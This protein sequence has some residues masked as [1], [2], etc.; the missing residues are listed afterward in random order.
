MEVVAFW[1][2]I[3]GAT[4]LQLFQ[5]MVQGTTSWL[6]CHMEPTPHTPAKS[7]SSLGLKFEIL[8]FIQKSLCIGQPM[9]TG[10]SNTW[11]ELK[12]AKPTDINFHN[13]SWFLGKKV[14]WGRFYHMKINLKIGEGCG[15]GADSCPIVIIEWFGFAS[16]TEGNY[17]F[18]CLFVYIYFG[19]FCP[20]PLTI[21]KLLNH[22]NSY[23][24][25]QVY[26]FLV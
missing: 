9:S 25:R 23:Q 16:I 18:V 10:R 20:F 7:S 6:S 26:C 5:G 4:L 17:I 12:R 3:A 14:Y 2:V 11:S 1:N 22:I 15:R 19:D 13:Q 24:E 21:K 8:I